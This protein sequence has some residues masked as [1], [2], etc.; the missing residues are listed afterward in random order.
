MIELQQF[1]QKVEKQTPNRQSTLML[2]SANY[3][4]A[5]EDIEEIEK[6]QAFFK[7]YGV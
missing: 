6:L 7:V 5:L 4:M 3:K 1:A 2:G